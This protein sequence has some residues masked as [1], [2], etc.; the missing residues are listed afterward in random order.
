MAALC[1]ETPLPIAFD[2]EL[3][4]ANTLDERIKLLDSLKP[5]YIVLKPSLHGGMRGSQ[6]WIDEARKRQI[7]WWITSA[8]ESNVGLN[9]IAQFCA[10]QNP[11]MPQGLGTGMLFTDNIDFPLEIRKDKLWFTGKTDVDFSKVIDNG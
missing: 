1:A 3:I 4:G 11:Q 7:G 10:A 5:Q 8:L 2:E 9:A 6:E